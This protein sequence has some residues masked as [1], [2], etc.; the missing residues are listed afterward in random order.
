[1]KPCTF[2]VDQ[3]LPLKNNPIAYKYEDDSEKN[4]SSCA[5]IDPSASS[6]NTIVKKPT[7]C[8]ATMCKNE[9]HCIKETMESIYKFI[10]YW[11]VCDTGSTDRTC[12][13]VL[14]F[15]REKNIPGELHVDEWV[16]FGHNKTLL[17]NRCYKKTDFF[18][19][20]DSDDL[21]VGEFIIPDTD[22][23]NKLSYSIN[24]KRGSCL[25]KDRL[26]FNSNYRW[27]VCGVA[28]NAFNCIDNTSHLESGDL[29]NEPFYIWSRDTGSRSNDETK[30]YNDA[31][32]LKAQFY[33]TLYHDEDNLNSRSCFYTAQSYFDCKMWKD[34]L[35]WYS[36]YI[37]LK[38]TWIEETYESHI[39]VAL[40]M[41]E[42]KQHSD[43]EIVDAIIKAIKLHDDRAEPYYILGLFFN[44]KSNYELGYFNFKMARSMD[45]DAVKSKYGLFVNEMSY[46]KNINI[47]LSRACFHTNRCD[48]GIQLLTELMNDEK[49]A[50]KSEVYEL[51]HNYSIKYKR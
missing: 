51:R 26:V 45:I 49:Y 42:L 31:V 1:M 22:Y 6:S 27:K 8:F 5:V 4:M 33:E 43:N 21:C 46:G 37:R 38:N 13:I 24:I 14:D 48:E 23:A 12:E 32:K 50:E 2:K 29:T 41:I 25:Y 19:H 20:F 28:H 7:I 30:Y 15:F 36:L 3:N 47:D 34:A 9:E 44:N 10:D 11:I 40:C 17:F 39:H 35:E 18:I 16:N